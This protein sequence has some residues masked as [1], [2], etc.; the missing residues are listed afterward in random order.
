MRVVLPVTA[1]A[2]AAGAVVGFAHRGTGAPA[3]AAASA[4]SDD[5]GAGEAA[6]LLAD[7]QDS[8]GA[9]LPGRDPSMEAQTSLDEAVSRSS[10]TS[11]TSKASGGAS[12]GKSAA[13]SHD[14][15]GMDMSGMTAQEMADM[16]KGTTAQRKAAGAKAAK[17]VLG[18]PR[19]SGVLSNGCAAGYGEV[20]QCVPA[21]APGGGVTTCA[22]VVTVFPKGVAVTGKDTLSLDADG[23]GIACDASD[24]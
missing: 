4:A 3:P 20:T 2:L 15:A 11:K 1:L 24:L 10:L 5:V 22:Y 19:I 14:M 12:S 18:D 17:K 6:A 16:G 7:V 23:D 13:G 21:H 8:S 9:P